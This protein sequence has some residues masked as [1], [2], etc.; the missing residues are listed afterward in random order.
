MLA[1]GHSK[2]C[3]RKPPRC[4]GDL[5]LEEIQR[6]QTLTGIAPDKLVSVVAAEMRG[7]D[8]LELTYKIEGAL[9]ERLLSRAD[10]DGIEIATAQRPFTFKGEAEPFQLACEAKRMDLAFLFDPMMAVHTANVDPL[11]HQITAVYE[12]MLP[13]QP[14]RFVLADDPG[15]GKTIMA[16]LYIRELIMRA[17]AKRILIVAPGSLVEQW[18]DEL[19]EKFGLEFRV[20]TNDLERSSANPNP[21]EE[22]NQL[23]VRLD[24][25]SRND[26]LRE[27]LCQAGW[28]LVVFDEAHKLAAHFFGTK[29]EKTGRY[30]L[31]EALGAV[32]RHL[33]LMTAQWQ[34]RRL[35]ALP[36]AAGFR[37]LLRQVHR[38]ARATGRHRLAA[39]GNVDAGR[40][41]EPHAAARRHRDSGQAPRGLPDLGHEPCRERLLRAGHRGDPAVRLG[42]GRQR[43][44][45][46]VQQPADARL[47]SPCGL[48]ALGRGRDGSWPG[49]RR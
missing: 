1:G 15:A 34:G 6:G 28:D 42:G 32:T 10:E 14:L 48:P 24:Q 40:H 36:V 20:F 23:I 35:S 16:G 2:T 43:P 47:L 30:Q 33:L 41:R 25:M 21:F 17:D 11:P 39:G 3:D 45:P 7:S 13:R 26:E 22:H 18:R 8:S 44:L 9:G 31:A 29:L 37:P 19:S 46:A 27:K 5:R 49:R 38:H 4:G 12:S